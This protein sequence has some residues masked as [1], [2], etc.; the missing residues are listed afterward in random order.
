MLWCY[1]SVSRSEGQ[2][3]HPV[4]RLAYDFGVFSGFSY[5]A[6]WLLNLS[7]YARQFHDACSCGQITE[8]HKFLY[9]S[10]LTWLSWL[11]KL[12][13]SSDGDRVG[14]VTW[15]RK[16]GMWINDPWS[17]KV[18]FFTLMIHK[19]SGHDLD[20]NV[21]ARPTRIVLKRKAQDISQIQFWL[22]TKSTSTHVV[23]VRFMVLC[24]HIL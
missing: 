11:S 10:N 5:T 22:E 3:T 12:Q 15:A 1:L 14:Q 23:N 13:L 4:W 9:Y 18:E 8:L 7:S 2:Q 16:V 19:I 20:Q 17:L 6:D 21:C 24:K